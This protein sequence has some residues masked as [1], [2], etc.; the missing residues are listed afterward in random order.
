MKS[1]CKILLVDDDPDVLDQVSLLLRSLRWEI[2][3]AGGRQEAEQVLLSFKPD[4]AIVDLMM[5]ERDSGFVL[6]HEIK[7]LYP[8]TPVIM[9]TAVRSATGISFAGGASESQSWIK[10]DV[11]LDKPVRPEE[12]EKAVRNLLKQTSQQTAAH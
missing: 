1:S 9:L 8:G 4:V 6:A 7:K 5:E 3:T 11:I 2:T 10:A 12:L